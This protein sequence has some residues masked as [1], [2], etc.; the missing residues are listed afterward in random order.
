MSYLYI[1]PFS[2]AHHGSTWVP[3]KTW[4]RRCRENVNSQT[5]KTHICNFIKG[6]QQL[7]KN[8]LNLILMM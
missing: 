6:L 7:L 5:T 4:H 2:A 8:A 3:H 1:S